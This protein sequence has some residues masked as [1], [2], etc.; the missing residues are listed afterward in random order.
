MIEVR[1]DD[2]EGVAAFVLERLGQ[3]REDLKA[4]TALG[5]YRGEELIGGFIYTNYRPIADSGFWSIDMHMAGN[6]GWLNRQ[7]LRSF[8]FYP[9]FE[10]KCSRV[11]GSVRA[12]NEQARSIVARLGAKL[13]GI[14]RS[15]IA[16]E[17]D[18]CVY[19]MTRQEC[20]W[21]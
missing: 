14:I 17:Y 6:P 19:T 7:T 18:T 10:L 12:G 11:V 8:H 9:F 13:D 20:P 21:F 5:A 4:F 1:G 3:K 16:P 15:G 2:P